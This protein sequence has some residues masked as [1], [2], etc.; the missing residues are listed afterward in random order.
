MARG[1]KPSST[2]T[3]GELRLI[4]VVWDR[5]QATVTEVVDA[6]RPHQRLAYNTVLTT[7][8]ILERK[9]YLRREKNGRAHVYHPLVNRDAARRSAVLDV[10]EQFFE[11]SPELLVLNVLENDELDDEDLHRLRQMIAAGAGG[12]KR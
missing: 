3:R 7:L 12:A 5:G 1:R 6:L 9:G 10:M 2:L 11:S 4:K 8:R